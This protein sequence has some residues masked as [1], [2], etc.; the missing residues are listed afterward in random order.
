MPYTKIEILKRR[1]YLCVFDM[2]FIFYFIEGKNILSKQK[3]K[4][5][6]VKNSSYTIEKELYEKLI[7]SI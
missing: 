5:Q 7:N 2:F 4:R 3:Q 1:D 6:R